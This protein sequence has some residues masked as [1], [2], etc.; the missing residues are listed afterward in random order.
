[1]SPIEQKLWDAMG[2][3]WGRID[4]VRL[5][6]TQNM[7]FADLADWHAAIRKPEVHALAV[8]A[9]Q[10]L[11]DPYRVDFGFLS[12][13]DVGLIR[14]S[15]ECDGHDFHERTKTQAMRDRTRDRALIA[16]GIKAVRFTGSEIWRHPIECVLE[17]S[18]I[19]ASEMQR[20][21]EI[22]IFGREMA[23]AS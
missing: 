4:I 22:S 17:I 6:T 19:A 5:S 1:M 11:H 16:D 13:G 20:Q 14:I 21:T 2:E 18:R 10:V 7:T 8:C 12:R 3:C 15:I 23:H 9:P